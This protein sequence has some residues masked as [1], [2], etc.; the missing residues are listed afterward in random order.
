MNP[1]ATEGVKGKRSP[2]GICYI[3]IPNDVK[4]GDYIQNCYRNG[5]VSVQFED[6]SMMNDI[7]IG[8]STLNLIDFP[9]DIKQLGS[10]CIYV[11]EYNHNKPMIVDRVLKDDESTNLTENEFQLQ[12]YTSTGSVSISGKAKDGNLFINVSGKNTVGGKIYIDVINPDNTGE[13]VVNLQGDLK[14]EMQNMILSIQKEVI[15][16]VKE[17]ILLTIL[18]G[19]NITAEEDINI[20]SE[21]LINLG[22][23]SEDSEAELEPVLLGTKTV[24]Q[25]DKEIQALTDLI[26]SIAN[27]VP[28]PVAT[29]SPDATWAA[30]QAVVAAII[31]RGDLS[32]V[33]SEKVFVE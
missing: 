9:E 18:K 16:E 2:N 20:N 11:T 24:D 19:L 10:A 28:A 15:A 6:G 29:G 30:W 23:T 5:T 4:R 25:L 7:I 33:K 14:A 32:A 21:T 1:V 27:I 3:I 12:K 31:Q 13:I 17:N 22:D 26:T 8:V